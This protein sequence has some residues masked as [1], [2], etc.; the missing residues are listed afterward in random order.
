MNAKPLIPGSRNARNLGDKKE[1]IQRLQVVW[2]NPEEQKIETLVDA[3]F[4][5]GRS[6]SASQVYCSVWI[7][8][9]DSDWSGYGAAGGGGYHK[10]SAALEESLRSAGWSL[11]E[12]IHGG[13]DRAMEEAVM[14]VGRALVGS[15]AVL[16][17][18]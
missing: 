18:L 7:Y 15:D 11:D 13:G 9:I 16:E 3:R 2:Y 1:T 6:S 17:V 10:E 5:M 4:Y 14:A 8:G 12:D